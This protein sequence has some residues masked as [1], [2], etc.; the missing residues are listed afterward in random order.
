MDTQA[1]QRLGDWGRIAREAWIGALTMTTEAE[2]P[3]TVK[4]SLV[5]DENGDRLIYAGTHKVGLGDIL[6]VMQREARVVAGYSGLSLQ[7]DHTRKKERLGK[8]LG[9]NVRVLVVKT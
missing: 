1:K 2:A 8:F 4:L 9:L 7:F 6:L 5:V 3:K